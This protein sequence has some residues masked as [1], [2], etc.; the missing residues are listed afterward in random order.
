MNDTPPEVVRKYRAM[1]LQR[2]GAE[3]VRM[4]SSM[5]ATTRTLLVA[6]LREKDPAVSPATLRRTLFLRLYGGD[7]D[8]ARR[9]RIVAALGS[10]EPGASESPREG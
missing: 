6:S 7:F 4:G 2:S 8:P 5:F 10:A 9:D 1:L 3:R